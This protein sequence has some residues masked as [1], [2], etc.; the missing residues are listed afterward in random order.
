MKKLVFFV[1]ISAF[2]LLFNQCTVNRQLSQAKA[3]GDCKFNI[4]SADS[5]YLS[6][7]DIRKLRNMEDLNPMRYPQIAAGL[8]SKSIP[9]SARLNIDITNPTNKV[10]AIN[11][12]EYKIQLADQELF[13]GFINQRIEVAPGGGST[14][15]PIKLNANAYQLLTDDKTR[16]AFTDLVRNMSGTNNTKPSVLTIKIKPTLALGNKKIDYPGYITINQEVTNKILTG[17]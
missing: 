6:G 4:A 8:L 12:L 17:Q 5:V 13:N 7:I 15:V 1:A 16:S 2:A 10:A 14:R 3:L 9:L 11:Q